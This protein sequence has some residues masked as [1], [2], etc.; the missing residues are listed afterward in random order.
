MLKHTMS[1][2][3]WFSASLC[4]LSL[5]SRVHSIQLKTSTRLSG[6]SAS[7][8]FSFLS[9]PSN[10]PKIVASSHSVRPVPGNSYSQTDSSMAVGDAVDE[11]FG[12]PP[13]LP[14]SVRWTCERSNAGDLSFY[15]PDGLPNVAKDCRM[16]FAIRDDDGMESKD[17]CLVDFTMEYDPVSPLATLAMPILEVDNNLAIKGLLPIWCK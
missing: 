1:P 8:A 5:Y 15:S 16:I 3:C 2:R 11:V 6:V 17:G 7:K 13:L 10:W 9:T 4:S 12:L 14:L